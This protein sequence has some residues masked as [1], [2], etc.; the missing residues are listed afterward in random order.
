MFTRLPR[1]STE[2]FA[3]AERPRSEVT[4]AAPTHLARSVANA[5]VLTGVTLAGPTVGPERPVALDEL[6]ALVCRRR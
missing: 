1:G 4:D 3:P 5:A 6:T 2:L